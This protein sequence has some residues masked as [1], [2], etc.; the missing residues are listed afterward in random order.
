MDPTTPAAGPGG[1][2]AGGPEYPV[3]VK[4]GDAQAEVD[5]ALALLGG[6]VTAGLHKLIFVERAAQTVVMVTHREA[7]LAEALR[8]R[9]WKEP[10][11]EQ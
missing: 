10:R 4:Q 5:A 1:A 6:A 3:F 7:P 8:A 11:E 2:A 9:N